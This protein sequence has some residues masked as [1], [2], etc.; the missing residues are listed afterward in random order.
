MQAI[1]CHVALTSGGKQLPAIE[2]E[3]QIALARLLMAQT[4]NTQ[5][6]RQ[7]LERAVSPSFQVCHMLLQG[8]L[9]QGTHARP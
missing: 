6:A 4:Q 8:P 3:S 2:V 7:R 1:K 5:E 9:Q